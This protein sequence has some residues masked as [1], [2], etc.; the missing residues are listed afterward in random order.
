MEENQVS[1]TVLICCSCF[2]V[3]ATLR[4]ETEALGDGSAVSVGWC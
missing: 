3:G 1:Y 2:A 4:W